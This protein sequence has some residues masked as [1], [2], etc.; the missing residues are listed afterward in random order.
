VP[1]FETLVQDRTQRD[2]TVELSAIPI[3]KF[4]RIDLQG[5]L[6]GGIMVYQAM[7]VTQISEGGIRIHTSAP[8]HIDSL[9]EIRL[10]LGP[11]TIVAK[12]RIVHCR[13]T[14][15]EGGQVTYRAG[16]EFVELSEHARTAIRTF[17]DRMRGQAAGTPEA[18]I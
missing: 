16:V 6:Q 18:A 2:A 3:Q 4:A 1:Y 13:L 12:G 8:L 10:S 14:E 11:I 5:D 17:V 15:L 7:N 9:H